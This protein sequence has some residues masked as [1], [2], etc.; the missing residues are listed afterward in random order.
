MNASEAALNS[1]PSWG[2]NP[3]CSAARGRFLVLLLLSSLVGAWGAAGEAWERD[4]RAKLGKSVTVEFRDV[5]LGEALQSL[6]KLADVPIR[7][8][9]AIALCKCVLTDDATRFSHIHLPGEVAIL[10]KLIC[11]QAPS[12]C[13]LPQICRNLRI[14]L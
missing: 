12:L 8:D 2:C 5:T 11:R 6:G 9:A 13:F 1:R 3:L 4:L 7:I 14:R 10:D